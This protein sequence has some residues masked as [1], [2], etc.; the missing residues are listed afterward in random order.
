M[1]YDNI[2]MT[3]NNFNQNGNIYSANNTYNIYYTYLIIGLRIEI[4]NKTKHIIKFIL[5]NCSL[6]SGMYNKYENCIYLVERIS[7]N[8][9]YTSINNDIKTYIETKLNINLDPFYFC[10]YESNLYRWNE[11]T[12]IDINNYHTII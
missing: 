1:G 9:S 4:N 8:N 2:Y 6:L 7:L 11:Y 10:M 3:Q 12:Y 5:S